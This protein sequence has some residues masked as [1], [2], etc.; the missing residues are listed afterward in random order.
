METVRIAILLTAAL[1]ASAPGQSLPEK[2]KSTAGERRELG[3]VCVLP[4]PTER[5]TR[6]SPGGDYNPATLTVRIDKEQQIPWPH[7]QPVRIENLPWKAAILSCSRPT[8]SGFNPFGFGFRTSKKLPYVSI[9]TA[10][11]ACN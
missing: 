6:I 9:L 10:I 1:A 7:Q 11:K 5:P 2:D 8:V 4:N 3:T